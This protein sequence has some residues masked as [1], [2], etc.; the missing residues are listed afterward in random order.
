MYVVG[1][2]ALTLLHRHDIRVGIASGMFLKTFV[3]ERS[4]RIEMLAMLYPAYWRWST[5]DLVIAMHEHREELTASGADAAASGAGAASRRADIYAAAWDKVEATMRDKQVVGYRDEQRVALLQRSEAKR[6]TCGKKG[7]FGYHPFS[8]PSS[9][10]TGASEARILLPDVRGGQLESVSKALDQQWAASGATYKHS[11]EV[12]AKHEISLWKRARYNRIRFL[13]WLFKAEG[14]SV[15]I[16]PEEWDFLKGMGAGAEKGCEVSGIESFDDAQ[17]A[18]AELRK[19][20]A[21]SGA[22][23]DLD[24]L[25]CWLCLSMHGE[26]QAGAKLPAPAEP[27]TVDADL[28]LTSQGARTRLR[29]KVF[30][31]PH[32]ASGA[33]QEQE[34]RAQEAPQP[35]GQKAPHP[36]GAQRR[37]CG[38]S[39][40]TTVLPELVRW[41]PVTDAG[42]MCQTCQGVLP[43][44]DATRA[45]VADT[46]AKAV[47]LQGP[48][49]SALLQ[50]GLGSAEVLAMRAQAWR[51]LDQCNQLGQDANSIAL[52][53][54]R[55]SAKFT[56][57]PVHADICLRFLPTWPELHSMECRLV[58]TLWTERSNQAPHFRLEPP[59]PLARP[60]VPPP[61]AR[62]APSRRR[63]RGLHPPGAVEV[64][65]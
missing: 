10:R 59:Q 52:A 62:P 41:L 11:H 45:R 53:L 2:S 9:R 42:S 24:D 4:R 55:L 23:F 15:E 60:A 32:A 65:P 46:V 28:C 64:A 61:L 16:G 35:P 58:I 20:P 1:G 22:R 37:L 40:L 48:L 56:L 34:A 21:A 33:P 19:L 63:W 18:C 49:A 51:W 12:L 7:R 17:A 14:M 5:R 8:N 30:H 3:P 26:A 29:R 13:R 27:V 25:I 36:P 38:T 39:V 43:V 31:L 54:L 50:A 44:L 6:I 57:T 47:S